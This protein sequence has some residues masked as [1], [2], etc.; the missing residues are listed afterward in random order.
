M[1]RRRAK[2]W[3]YKKK[4]SP[5]AGISV[6][7]RLALLEWNTKK[8]IAKKMAVDKVVSELTRQHEEEVTNQF[9][10]WDYACAALALH[11][12]YGHGAEECAEF[13]GE[14]QDILKTYRES[15]MDHATIWDVV[16]EEIGLD[17]IV[18]D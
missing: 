2:D 15:G 14:M 17:V 3:Q 16:R 1:S 12:R 11:R 10:D 6:A 13:L 7:A 18:E 5:D 8:D 9:T 4:P